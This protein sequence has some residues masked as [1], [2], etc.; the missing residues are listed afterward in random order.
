MVKGKSTLLIRALTVGKCSR[1][2]PSL[3]QVLAPLQ[4][5]SSLPLVL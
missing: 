4:G 1:V 2:L 3:G 5:S